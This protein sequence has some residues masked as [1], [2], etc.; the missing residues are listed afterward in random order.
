MPRPGVLLML[1]EVQTGLGRCG[2]WFAFQRLG[3]S[4]DVV[5]MAKALGNG[6]PIGACWARSEVADVFEPGDHGTTFGGQPLAAA[7]A[8]TVLDVMQREDVCARAETAGSRF[9]SSLTLR[10]G[11]AEV[12]GLGLLLAIELEGVDAA[13]A[14]ARLLDRGV[15]VNAVSPTA[16]RIAPSLLI[17]DD[18][19]EEGAEAIGGVVEALAAAGSSDARA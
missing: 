7:A 4:P 1:D 10:R 17:T 15:V 2:S 16:L 12:R 8:R 3:I 18:E 6:V 11:V 5:T 19:V 9:R 13:E 14:A